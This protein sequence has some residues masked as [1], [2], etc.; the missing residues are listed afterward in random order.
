[1][2]PSTIVMVTSE[3]ERRN[4]PIEAYSNKI[5]TGKSNGWALIYCKGPDGEQL[6][7]V[8]ALDPVKKAFHDASEARRRTVAGNR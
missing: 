1:M 5:T 7:F 6:E 8:Q 2:R 3:Q 4:A